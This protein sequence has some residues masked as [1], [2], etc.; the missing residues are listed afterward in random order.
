MWMRNA[1]IA[2]LLVA[3]CARAI[4]AVGPKLP[5]GPMADKARAACTGCHDEL[6]IMQQQ[7][8]RRVWTKEVDKMI[9]WGAP[10][11][12]QDREALTEYLASHFPPQ[13]ESSGRQVTGG[14]SGRVRSAHRPLKK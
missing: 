13:Q 4:L 12:P 6:I 8:N 5:P 2:A 11:A 7:L 10:V 14:R 3:F 1:A 9:R